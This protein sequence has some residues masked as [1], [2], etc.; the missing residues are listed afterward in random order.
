MQD[1]QTMGRP[2]K[3][4]VSF[5][6]EGKSVARDNSGL[7]NR[8]FLTSERTGPESEPCE[9]HSPGLDEEEA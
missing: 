3:W 4:T 9:S 7:N 6:A 8:V 1:E 2:N 5:T